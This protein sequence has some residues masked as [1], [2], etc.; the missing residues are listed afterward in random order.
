M[1]DGRRENLVSFLPPEILSE[2]MILSALPLDISIWKSPVLSIITI[3]RACALSTPRMWSCIHVT[4][5]THASERLACWFQR[6]GDGCPLY[7]TVKDM[8]AFRECETLWLTLDSVLDHG[9]RIRSLV[10]DGLAGTTPLPLRFDTTNLCELDVVFSAWFPVKRQVKRRPLFDNISSLQLTR[11]KLDYYLASS[12]DDSLEWLDPSTL[13]TLILT[14][15]FPYHRVLDILTRAPLLEQLDWNLV[16]QLP[17]SSEYFPFR[18][19]MDS[20]RELKLEGDDVVVHY[21]RTLEAPRLRRLSVSGAWD[22]AEL[23]TVIEFACQCR[24]L[25]H[26][27]I[28]PWNQTPSAANVASL[29][30]DLPKLEYLDPKW[31]EGNIEGILALCGEFPDF[32]AQERASWPCHSISRLQLPLSLLISKSQNSRDLVSRCITRVL[33][34]RGQ[35]TPLHRN[36]DLLAV[37]QEVSSTEPPNQLVL[38]VD[39]PTETIVSLVGHEWMHSAI[40]CVE[41]LEFPNIM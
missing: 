28:L 19:K 1:A 25:T 37:A 22:E 23:L 13:K 39:V 38:V 26:L 30:R 9:R 27:E 12:Q 8:E 29:F 35:R 14:P 17:G 34:A 5:G 21:L 4:R 36:G 31:N 16:Y 32:E 2:V 7:L 10:F 6:A 11:L 33:N 20:L 18:M 15:E 41:S 24:K 40:E 3:W